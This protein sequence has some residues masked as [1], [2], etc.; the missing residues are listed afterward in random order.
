MPAP[1]VWRFRMWAAVMARVVYEQAGLAGTEARAR[2]LAIDALGTNA[3]LLI[4]AA[5]IAEERGFGGR[6]ELHITI[7]SESL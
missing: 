3:H 7:S 4:D 6:V 1:T 2:D 5:R